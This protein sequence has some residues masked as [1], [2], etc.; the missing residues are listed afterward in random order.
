MTLGYLCCADVEDEASEDEGDDRGPKKAATPE[1]R[2]EEVSAM[3]PPIAPS[4]T[5]RLRTRLFA[6]RCLQDLPSSVGDD[7][8]H[9]DAHAAAVCSS[10]SAVLP[11][12]P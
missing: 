2:V 11:H 7:P 5:P 6:A 4:T 10:L 8:R 9:F 3:T 1:K 12:C